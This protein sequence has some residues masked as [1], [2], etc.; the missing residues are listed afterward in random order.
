MGE[1]HTP[2]PTTPQLAHPQ[3]PNPQTRRVAMRQMRPTRHR[4]R[5]HRGRRRPLANQPAITMRTTPPREDATRSPSGQ[6]ST[7][8]TRAVADRTTPRNGAL[9]Q[10]W[11]CAHCGKT[12][13]RK[14]VRGQRPKYC[15]RK[16]GL[17]ATRC[18]AAIPCEMC[19]LRPARND[20]RFCS[21]LCGNTHRAP[22]C[23]V[24]TSHPSRQTT[25][26]AQAI[27]K[28]AIAKAGTVAPTAWAAVPCK[29]CGQQFLTRWWGASTIRCCSP[30]C[31]TADKLA[32]KRNAK[33]VRRAR[34]REAYVADVYRLD[35][36]KRDGWRCH[37]CKQKVNR[38]A[39][40][41]HPRAATLDH[42]IPLGMGGTH[43]PTNVATAHFICNAIKGNRLAGDQ[44]ALIG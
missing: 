9:I 19:G 38:K 39:V 34:Q 5:P 32:L 7:Q 11:T 10:T 37:I 41:P 3:I 20:G 30:I 13:T 44:L 6:R 4:R 18:S 33:H 28:A 25:R 2:R 17:A 8:S 40:A 27:A 29:V 36:Y 35:I 26:L 1:Q 24:P 12:A 14:A 16:C 21:R 43:E 42:L 15:T 22:T 23:E 31:D